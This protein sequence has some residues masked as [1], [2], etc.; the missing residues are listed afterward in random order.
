MSY[1]I[2]GLICSSGVFC[3]RRD[4]RRCDARCRFVSI[5]SHGVPTLVS[6]KFG[7]LIWRRYDRR[8]DDCSWFA[9]IVS[10]DIPSLIYA[11]Y[12]FRRWPLMLAS[13]RLSS[14]FSSWVC[15][16]H[17]C[18]PEGH[19]FLIITEKVIPKPRI[20]TE[21]RIEYSFRVCDLSSC[22]LLSETNNSVLCTVL[23]CLVF[24]LLKPSSPG[25]E[26]RTFFGFVTFVSVISL[27]KQTTLV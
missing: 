21:T 14:R 9:S 1:D 16:W 2:A 5:V 13:R 4:D 24:E 18:H 15:K 10:Y 7:M 23:S 17:E 12:I 25:L 8:R 11:M 27:P 22:N 20:F 6:D 3:G 19:A 26:P